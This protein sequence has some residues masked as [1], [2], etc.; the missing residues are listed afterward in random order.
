MTKQIEFSTNGKPLIVLEREDG[1][2]L[3]LELTDYALF[4]RE[5]KLNG[6]EPEGFVI[7]SNTDEGTFNSDF[8]ADYL[9]PHIGWVS[10][11][12]AKSIANALRKVIT[13]TDRF[14]DREVFSVEFFHFDDIRDYDLDEFLVSCSLAS[15]VIPS[16]GGFTLISPLNSAEY[17]IN[18]KNKVLMDF[19]EFCEL[20][21]FMY[22]QI[23]NEWFKVDK[24]K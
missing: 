20:G 21:K 6:W 22:M 4:L 19:I 9:F 14:L 11:K 23:I 24:P 17:L 1:R 18:M 2:M 12:D 3:R 13:Q 10:E 8:E 15:D 5:A 7:V 16:M